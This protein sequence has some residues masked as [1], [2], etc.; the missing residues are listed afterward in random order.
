MGGES[1]EYTW[2]ECGDTIC[3][4]NEEHDHP[5]AKEFCK[6]CLEI[7]GGNDCATYLIVEDII[8]AEHQD[9]IEDSVSLPTLTT[10]SNTIVFVGIENGASMAH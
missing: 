6:K 1:Y 8:H 5:N 7:N 10:D 9:K 2:F 4:L 3:T